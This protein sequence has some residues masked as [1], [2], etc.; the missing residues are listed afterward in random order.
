MKIPFHKY[1]GTGNDFIIIDNR[2]DHFGNL[3][4]NDISF[5]C[6]RSFG[7]GADGL[8]L[9]NK[10][11]GFDFEMLY[12]NADGKPSS[13]CG[14]GSR[15]IVRFASD[16]G[17]HKYSYRFLA[18]DGPHDAEIDNEGLIRVRMNDVNKVEQHTGYSLLNTGSPHFVKFADDVKEIDVAET[19]RDIRN[20]KAF[21]KEGVNVNFVETLDDDKIFVRTY[22]RG[23]EDET[24]SCGTGV[25]ASALL[26]AHNEKGFNRVDVITPGGELSVEFNRIDESHFDNIWLCGPAEKVFSGEIE[27]K[28]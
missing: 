22:E 6:D 11:P 24:L 14:N 20:S 17:M 9:F 27:I 7:I 10:K 28:Q 4:S 13:L 12:Y 18:A 23:V 16:L 25:T 5:L 2:E 15:C 19:G 26:A 21:V 1:Q 8:I 3:S